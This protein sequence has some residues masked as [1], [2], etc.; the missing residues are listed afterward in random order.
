VLSGAGV[1]WEHG[2]WELIP[3]L[4]HAAVEE[5]HAGSFVLLTNFA[6]NAVI[7]LQLPCLPQDT[8]QLQQ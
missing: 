7:C 4:W 2:M 5:V 3:V 1:V 8:V 6:F